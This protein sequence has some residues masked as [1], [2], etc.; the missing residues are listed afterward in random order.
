MLSTSHVLFLWFVYSVSCMRRFCLC[1][2]MHVNPL[3]FP[4]FG[5][6]DQYI[7][8][9]VITYI[10]FEECE[11]FWIFGARKIDKG[12]AA[13]WSECRARGWSKMTVDRNKSPPFDLCNHQSEPSSQSQT[14]HFMCLERMFLPHWSVILTQEYC[15]M[16][17]PRSQTVSY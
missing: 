7:V 16:L 14:P 17:L 13:I 9:I 3:L 11:L 10:G 4:A 15:M 6:I 1:A 12:V 5:S 2:C 8:L